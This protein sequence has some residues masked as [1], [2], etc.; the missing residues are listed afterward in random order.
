M[1]I[2]YSRYSGHGTL[3]C[4]ASSRHC[5]W[6]LNSPV[7]V[8]AVLPTQKARI[9]SPMQTLTCLQ[10]EVNSFMLGG[11]MYGCLCVK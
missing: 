3:G 8:G 4:F 10:A 9:T 11:F 5:R 1:V 2:P 6:W 7:G